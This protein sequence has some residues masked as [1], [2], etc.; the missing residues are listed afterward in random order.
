V[1]DPFPKSPYE[2]THMTKTR[3]LPLALLLGCGTGQNADTGRSSPQP[4]P[5][6][7]TT[8]TTT[9]TGPTTQDKTAYT[10]T[11][12][13]FDG[14]SQKGDSIPVGRK[15]VFSTGVKV[16]T[17]DVF[18][19]SMAKY[20]TV[21]GKMSPTFASAQTLVGFCTGTGDSESNKLGTYN[22]SV[23]SSEITWVDHIEIHMRPDDGKTKADY[24]SA[25]SATDN[26]MCFSYRTA[27]NNWH[28]F[29]TPYE[30]SWD[31]STGHFVM[32]FP[33]K[34]PMIRNV[35][36]FFNDGGQFLLLDKVVIATDPTK[37]TAP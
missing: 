8:P 21:T 26:R 17:A 11:F 22:G 7:T 37:N 12:S 35:T 5:T 27:D 34:K 2:R 31:D 36:V 33:L 15:I 6:T 10:V 4:S 28:E 9:A 29:L 24:F 1:V 3:L 32:T 16:G 13:G 19:K 14:F 25:V 18:D 30:P 23:E 20:L